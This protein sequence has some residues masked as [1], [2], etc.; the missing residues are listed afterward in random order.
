MTRAV[1]RPYA[2]TVISLNS[3]VQHVE[4]SLKRTLE[5][6]ISVEHAIG[7]LD[8]ARAIAEQ[9]GGRV[10]IEMVPGTGRICRAYFPVVE[11]AVTAE[12][13]GH[14]TILLVDDTEA[15]RDMIQRVLAGFG[16][17]VLLA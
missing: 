8:E 7:D 17:T 13:R 15:L 14:E 16:Y 3:V 9:A 4:P 12:E 1:G 11:D 10:H 6:A 5:P 2:V